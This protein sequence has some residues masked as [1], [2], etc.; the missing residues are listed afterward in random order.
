MYIR[1][2]LY[3]DLIGIQDLLGDDIQGLFVDFPQI[4]TSIMCVY[5]PPQLNS[6]SLNTARETIAGIVDD[7]LIK[8]QNRKIVILG[9]FNSFNVKNLCSD[10]NLTDIIT[11]PT[12]GKNILD[13]VL[14][15]EDLVQFYR[16]ASISV[17]APVGKSDHAT[18]VITP[19][20]KQSE[21]RSARYYNIFDYRASNIEKLEN[22]ARMINWCSIV[23]PDEDINE[24][25]QKLHATILDLIRDAIPQNTVKM[26]SRDKD[27]MTPIT[28]L[29]I[30]EKWEAYRHKDWKRF[31][32]LK[33]K[34]KTEIRKAKYTRYTGYAWSPK[35]KKSTDGLW[36]LAKEFG[37]KSATNE[38]DSLIANYPSPR[39]LA[40]AIAS[41]L[42]ADG[43]DVSS[44]WPLIDE[45]NES[46]W[47]FEVSEQEVKKHLLTLNP[48]KSSG[49]DAIP[50]KVYSRL[51]FFLAHPLKTI[52]EASLRRKDF[53]AAWKKG[54]MVPLPKTRPAKID[55]LRLITL[56][57][58]PA[59]IL[60]KL[61]LKNLTAHLERLYGQNQHAFRKE[62]STTTA[63]ID[64][65]DTSLFHFDDPSTPITGI[66]SL[67]F[68]KAFDKVE[69]NVLLQKILK[70]PQLQGFASWL[71]SY[72][73]GRTFTVRIQGEESTQ[74]TLDVGVPQG[75]VL[76][77]S[78][79]SVLVGDLPNSN[80]T[81]T[82]VQYAD[83]VN[84]IIPFNTINPHD[85]NTR[86]Q[87]Q[88]EEVQ[89][90][91]TKNF[92]NLNIEKSKL[93]LI[94]RKGT[95]NL[96][97]TMP[98]QPTKVLKILGVHLNDTLQW[99]DHI[100]AT[101]KRACQRLHI[102]RTLKEHVSSEELHSIYLAVISSIFD[103]CC[104]AF[105]K[106]PDK[107][108]K[109]IQRIEKRAHRI[110]YGDNVKCN[111][112]L[113]GSIVRRE[114]L[115][116]DLFNRILKNPRHILHN[117]APKHLPHQ[118]RLSNIL[119]RTSKRQNSFFPFS[120]LLY[121]NQAVHRSE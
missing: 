23:D 96:A 47:P 61:I 118:H 105:I 107:L 26:T 31:N 97:V 42:S 73:S 56:L 34:T 28:K 81:N 41:G 66:L 103:Y 82:F 95:S 55:K 71:Q 20:H 21:T 53:P 27:W 7:H 115:S 65:L 108:N 48:S 113:D 120:T 70:L 8:H 101:A 90:W 79:F 33:S 32:Y 100:A 93:L 91:C 104:P 119:C 45:S 64:I 40:E 86:I 36:K 43:K 51:A 116:M 19:L 83:D 106:L 29:I 74:Y 111:C 121:N 75:S 24:Q 12:R 22:N 72:L 99:D 59:K 18:I 112:A 15:S 25:W 67:D 85:I 58:V 49:S 5:L 44:K 80:S 110:I 60:E 39:H 54:I 62:A 87:R 14:V 94:T 13:H 76:G 109:R 88:L 9:D 10:L 16:P 89:T 50:N 69:H 52:F 114:T 46:A 102:L 1:N 3:Y 78:L 92:Q 98:I 37:G 117:K 68:S 35:L 4:E 2:T 63:I 84:I 57:P 38:M 77:P 11:E 6:L 30:Q 17:E